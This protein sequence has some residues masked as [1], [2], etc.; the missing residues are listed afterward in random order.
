MSDYAKTYLKMHAVELGEP[1]SVKTA[2]NIVRTICYQNNS[3]LS[4]GMIVAGWDRHDGGS[5][6]TIPLRGS[7]VQQPFSIGGSGSTYIYGYCDAN[8]REN[9]SAEECKT[10]VKNALSLAMAR[11]GSSG[12]VIRLAQID[13]NGVQREM[14][15]GD[16]LPVHW[17]G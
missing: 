5:V 13:A 12:G 2:A 17:E 8:F 16:K 1:A 11:D 14:I 9:M 15:E 7:L 10:F 6:W 3:F 4:A